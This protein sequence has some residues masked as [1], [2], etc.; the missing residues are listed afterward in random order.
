MK[1]KKLVA[2]IVGLAIAILVAI[3]GQLNAPEAP[4]PKLAPVELPSSPDAG[5]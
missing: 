2:T 4:A 3:Q 1:N 5:I